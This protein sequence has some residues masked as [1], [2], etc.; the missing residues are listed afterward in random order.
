MLFFYNL[1][2]SL[3]MSEEEKHKMI[4]STK[5]LHYYRTLFAQMI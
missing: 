3:N 2:Q 5:E 4:L 1:H